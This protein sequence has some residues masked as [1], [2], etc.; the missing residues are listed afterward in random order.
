M[1]HRLVRENIVFI[2]IDYCQCIHYTLAAI[3]H[4]KMDYRILVKN[5]IV[6]DELNEG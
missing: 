3:I 5:V 6:K 4:I 2:A 1:R